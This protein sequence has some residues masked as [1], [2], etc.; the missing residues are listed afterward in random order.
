MDIYPY[1]I[2]TTEY[3]QDEYAEEISENKP[4]VLIHKVEPLP[5]HK[6]FILATGDMLIKP[7]GN[8]F[9]ISWFESLPLSS[10][11]SVFARYY[12]HNETV[13]CILA[14]NTYT[15]HAFSPIK[16]SCKTTVLVHKPSN[17]YSRV[18]P[19]NENF[20]GIVDG[21]AAKLASECI[22]NGVEVEVLILECHKAMLPKLA[23]KYL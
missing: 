3:E 4:A 13:Y 18:C 11:N 15:P 12:H 7:I 17:D 8:L 19:L 6:R 2:V 9:G 21:L 23:Q 1:N 5:P 22:K 14:S 20:D 16:A 10:E